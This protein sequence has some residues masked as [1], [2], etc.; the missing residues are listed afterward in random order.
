MEHFGV[1]VR[2]G[3][4]GL[5]LT[6]ANYAVIDN[7]SSFRVKLQGLVQRGAYADETGK[8]YTDEWCLAYKDV[9]LQ[10]FDLNMQFF[11]SLNHDEFEQEIANFLLKNKGFVEVRDLK[12]WQG[13]G[14][15]YLMVLDK[16]CQVYVGTTDDIKRRIQQHWAKSKNFDRLLFPIYA[17][18]KSVLSIDSFRA[19]D[20]TRIFAQKTKNTYS[21]EDNFINT[22][23]EKFVANRIGGGKLENGML[24]I[25]QKAATIKTKGLKT[26]K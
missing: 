15:Y 2:A 8:Y 23:S 10:N 17:V 20:T 16:Y 12:E 14:G 9:C 26:D 7:K 1:P 6:R 22:F 18:E 4:Y 25:I 3:K 13:V 19:L 11:S 24:G 5:E 21:K